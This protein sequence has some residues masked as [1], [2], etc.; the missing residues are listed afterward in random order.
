MALGARMPSWCRRGQDEMAMSRLPVGH[1]AA[2]DKMVKGGFGQEDDNIIVLGCGSKVSVS[3]VLLQAS[4]TGK[5]H[6]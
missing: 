2:A 3:A 5:G 6:I 4:S 1:V